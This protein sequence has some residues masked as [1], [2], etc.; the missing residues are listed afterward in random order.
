V[1]V[2]DLTELGAALAADPDVQRCT[3]TRVWNWAMGHGDVI[4]QADVVPDAVIQPL[5]DAYVDGGHDLRA[6][7]HAVYSSPDFV[8]F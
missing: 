5:V 1:P 2:E 7:I 3:I 4:G 6:A 8:R